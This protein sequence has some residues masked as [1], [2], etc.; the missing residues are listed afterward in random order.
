MKK[1]CKHPRE[2]VWGLLSFRITRV[3]N[4]MRGRMVR[5]QCFAC[6]AYLPVTWPLGS[7]S[8]DRGRQVKQE[9]K[10]AEALANTHAANSNED[11]DLDLAV[12]FVALW[13][14]QGAR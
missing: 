4:R 6:G 5:C 14:A 2:R 9:M 11:S 12:D 7:E 13:H 10:L 1:R 8:N 3:P